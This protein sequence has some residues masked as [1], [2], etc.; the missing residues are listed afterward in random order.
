MYK[1]PPCSSPKK[2]SEKLQH[3]T[4]SNFYILQFKT[5]IVRSI[6]WVIMWE[7]NYQDC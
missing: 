5:W 3:K 1:H 6:A 4:N 2:D 7:S